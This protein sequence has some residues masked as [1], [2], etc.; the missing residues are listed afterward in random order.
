[1][2]TILI[3][4][5]KNLIRDFVTLLAS[6]IFLNSF[7]QSVNNVIWKSHCVLMCVVLNVEKQSNQIT[8]F[9]IFILRYN[10]NSKLFPRSDQYCCLR[11]L[12]NSH[13]IWKISNKCLFLYSFFSMNSTC[14]R[15][16]RVVSC[17][18][19]VCSFFLRLDNKKKAQTF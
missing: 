8:E 3:N 11:K 13:W 5:N 1:M 12:K 4:A 18:D 6:V 2:A 17:D 15:W 19:S 10:F 14:L 7:Y 9:V 16:L